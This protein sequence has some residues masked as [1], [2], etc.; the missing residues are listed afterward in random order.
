MGSI[1][2]RLDEKGRAFIDV[3]I[4]PSALYREA[5]GKDKFKGSGNSLLGMAPQFRYKAKALI[6]TGASCTSID[7]IVAEKLK[8]RMA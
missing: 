7:L 6:D 1:T 4:T 3:I 5:V 8:N 2:S